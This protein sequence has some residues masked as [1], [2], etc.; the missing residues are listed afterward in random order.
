MYEDQSIV[1][2]L[3]SLILGLRVVISGLKYTLYI[4]CIRASIVKDV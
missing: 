1:G 2:H 4:G 3:N